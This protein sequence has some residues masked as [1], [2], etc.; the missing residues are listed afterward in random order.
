MGQVLDWKQSL[1]FKA[2]LGNSTPLSFHL[3]RATKQ[4]GFPDTRKNSLSEALPHLV[5]HC[6]PSLD[7]RGHCTT[8]PVHH[9]FLLLP[10]ILPHFPPTGSSA[11]TGGPRTVVVLGPP[12]GIICV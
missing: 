4:T 6:Q 7:S 10:I 11:C 1:D 8:A 12:V 2:P 5:Q 9:C 3:L